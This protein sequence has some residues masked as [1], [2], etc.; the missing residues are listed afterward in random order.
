MNTWRASSKCV[1]VAASVLLAGC[2]SVS[3][4]RGKSPDLSLNSTKSPQQVGQCVAS[5]WGEFYGVNINQGPRANGGYSVSMPSIYTGNNGILD[6]T[7]TPDGAH[8]EVKYRLSGL[9]GYAKFT[10]VVDGCA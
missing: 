10:K 3:G 9:G 4:L 8:I 6:A 5:G 1:F 2:A 7:A